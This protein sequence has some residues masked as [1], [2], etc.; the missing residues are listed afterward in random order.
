M[1]SDSLVYYTLYYP[2]LQKW[3]MTIHANH[4]RGLGKNGK[5]K[6]A[7]WGWAMSANC[8]QFANLWRSTW[9]RKGVACFKNKSLYA[10][11][12]SPSQIYYTHCSFW[13]FPEKREIEGK[14]QRCTYSSRLKYKIVRSGISRGGEMNLR[15]RH[16][17]I[18]QFRLLSM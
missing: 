17:S 12:F 6:A 7:E 8:R 2:S 10:L 18:I 1:S 5:E 15:L 3:I 13:V 11:L 16:S 4:E 9:P 14:I